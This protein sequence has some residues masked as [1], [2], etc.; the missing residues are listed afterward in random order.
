MPPLPRHKDTTRP[1]DVWSL[2]VLNGVER[3]TESLR[4]G[5]SFDAVSVAEIEALCRRVDALRAALDERLA[6]LEDD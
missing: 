2:F 4:R 3:M 5:D 6:V 1:R